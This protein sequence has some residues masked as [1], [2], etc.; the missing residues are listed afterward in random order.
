MGSISIAVSA[1]KPR[2]VSN[3]VELEN[4]SFNQKAAPDIDNGALFDIV[5]YQNSLLIGYPQCNI[6]SSAQK[7]YESPGITIEMHCKVRQKI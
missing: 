6:S 5:K 1:C 4:Y 2:H 7:F 3:A